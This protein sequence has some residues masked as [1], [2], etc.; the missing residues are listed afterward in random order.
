M[1]TSHAGTVARFT[2][3]ITTDITRFYLTLKVISSKNCRAMQL[4]RTSERS[5]IF[6]QSLFFHS[7]FK[8]YDLTVVSLPEHSTSFPMGNAKIFRNFILAVFSFNR[9]E[10][11]GTNISACWTSLWD[12]KYRGL[13]SSTLARDKETFAREKHQSWSA[14]S[15]LSTKPSIT[16]LWTKSWKRFCAFGGSLISLHN[17]FTGRGLK[18]RTCHNL[19]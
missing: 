19:C 1:L 11:K 9:G 5:L 2:L 3:D 12:F 15:D 7:Y 14:R 4:I 6:R 17:A 13:W 10:E 18:P 16:Y 8:L